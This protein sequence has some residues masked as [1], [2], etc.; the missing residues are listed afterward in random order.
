[1]N[2]PR[3]TRRTR[4]RRILATA[5][6]AAA[7][8]LP[9]QAQHFG[10]WG[11]AKPA[12][13]NDVN[14]P[15]VEGCPIESQDGLDLYFASTRDGSYGHL[16]IFRAHR[17]SVDASWGPVTN[18]GMALNSA[19]ADYCPTPLPGKWLLF[20]SARSTGTADACGDVQPPPAGMPPA[21]DIYISHENPAHGWSEPLQLGCYPDGPNT[22]GHEFSPSLVHT[23]QGTLLYFSSNGYPDSQGHDI[24]VSQVLADGSVTAGVRVA[25]LST[26]FNDLMPNLRKDGLEIVFTS[27][28][29]GSAGAT[30]IYI[31]SR[32]STAD[33]WGAPQ[34]IDNGTINTA[35]GE[36]RPSLSGDGTR[37]H[38]G[39]D[40]DIYVSTRQKLK[41]GN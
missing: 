16:D 37:L 20:V 9:V 23:D 24:Y 33:P 41:G 11:D 25:E 39:R 13:G 17:D 12:S 38:F 31:A 36:S 28:R 26:E 32:A 30:D 10:P 8:T 18:A 14:T 34:R 29:P 3:N 27:N 6:A 22:P 19:A 4:T 40:N 2:T 1:M 21:G 35:G 7:F 15:A 5:I